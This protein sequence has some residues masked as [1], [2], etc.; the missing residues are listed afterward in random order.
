MDIS[1]MNIN[2]RYRKFNPYDE[3]VEATKDPEIV[4]FK[5][6]FNVTFGVIVCFDI[7]LNVPGN[8]LIQR[9]IRNF[10]FSTMWHNSLPYGTG[11]IYGLI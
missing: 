5:T 3:G 1:P 8:V 10:V 2:F 11:K 9:G 7:M 6:D 4:T